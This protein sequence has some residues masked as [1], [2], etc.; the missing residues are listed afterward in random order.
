MVQFVASMD[1][2]VFSSG[3]LSGFSIDNVRIWGG[4]PCTSRSVHGVRPRRLFHFIF[5][6]FVREARVVLASRQRIVHNPS[7]EMSGSGVPGPWKAS[8][9]H[10]Q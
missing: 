5:H 8:V 6:L 4:A 7:P 3:R 1:V 10:P 2:R 9:R